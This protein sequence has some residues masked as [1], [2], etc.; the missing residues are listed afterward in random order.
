M[1]S[2]IETEL[3]DETLWRAI[4]LFGRNVASYKF[5]LGKAL[6]EL[7]EE[8]KTFV[9]L[10][11]LAG[12]YSKHLVEHLKINDRQGTSKSSRFLNFCRNFNENV[13]SKNELRTRTVELGFNNVIDAFHVVGKDEIPQESAVYFWDAFSRQVAWNNGDTR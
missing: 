6:L 5:A 8:E 7:A 1:T 9:T 4:I 2:F 13:I 11:E 12:P 10:E 3:T